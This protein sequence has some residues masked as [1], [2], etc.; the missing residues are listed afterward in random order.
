MKCAI[1]PPKDTKGSSYIQSSFQE[2]R[3]ISN[4][5]YLGENCAYISEQL[6]YKHCCEYSQLRWVKLNPKYLDILVQMFRH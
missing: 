6:W 3:T 1:E 4:Y 5:G 2:N